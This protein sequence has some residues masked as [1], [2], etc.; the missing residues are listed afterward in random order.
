MKRPRA[1]LGAIGKLQ[2]DCVAVLSWLR[3][4]DG[5]RR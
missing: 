5:V 3:N 1:F 4:A 2:A